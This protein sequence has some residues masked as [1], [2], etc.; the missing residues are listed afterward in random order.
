MKI[1]HFSILSAT[2]VALL[3]L[4]GAAQAGSS[5]GLCSNATL[6]GPYGFTGHGE[7]LGLIGPDGSVHKYSSSGTLSLIAHTF[8]ANCVDLGTLQSLGFLS[9]DTESGQET[10]R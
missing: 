10:V 1:K 2:A 9:Q 6:K 8:S 4:S 3:S 7:I 5:G